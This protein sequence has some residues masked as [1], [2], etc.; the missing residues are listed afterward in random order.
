MNMHRSITL[1]TVE[2]QEG[3]AKP[4]TQ[5][6]AELLDLFLRRWKLVAAVSAVV[7][8]LVYGYLLTLTPLY[9]ATTVL[10]FEP[11]TENLVGQNIISGP[12]LDQAAIDSQL[13]AIGSNALLQRVVTDQNLLA[14]PEFGGKPSA[15]MLQRVT[16]ILTSPFSRAAPESEPTG[17]T[18]MAGAVDASSARMAL[19]VSRLRNAIEVQ[20]QPRAWA[21]NISVT[22]VNRAKAATLAD[23]VADAFIDDKLEARYERARRAANWLASRIEVLGADVKKAEQAVAEYRARYNIAE[24]R[25]ATLSD[26][27][28]TD[29]NGRLVNLRAETAEKRVKFEQAKALQASGNLD[30]IPDVVNSPVVAGLRAQA[31][32]VTR[33]EADLLARYGRSHPQVINV[34]AEK[35]DIERQIQAEAQRAIT[36][37]KND[38]DLAASR[39]DALD[40]SLGRLHAGNDSTVI[41]GLRELERTASANKVLY[42]SFLSRAKVA[43]EEAALESRDV[44]VLTNALVPGSPSYPRTNR[45]LAIALL[46]GLAL[47]AG[48]AFALEMLNRG[49]ISPRQVEAALNLPV[50]ASLPMVAKRDL[51]AGM[52]EFNIGE[53]LLAKPLSH[54]SEAIRS[55][56]TSVQMSDVDDPP[57]VIQV[58]SSI[59][60]EGKTT[61]CIALATSAAMIGHKVLLIDGDLR[62]PSTSRAFGLSRAQGLVDC[63]MAH[64]DL[65]PV[66]VDPR[67]GVHVLPAGSRTQHPPDLLNSAR[68]RT[69]MAEYRRQY[70]YIIMDSPPL[71]P[72]IDGSV[73]SLLADKVVF[74]VSWNKAPRELVAEAIQSIRGPRKTA[75]V[76][77][78]MVDEAAMPRYGRYAY[79]G[80]ST[81]G[82]YYSG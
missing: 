77:F 55:V 58:T 28:I 2:D 1:P 46:A 22:S 3:P 47:G 18:D 15:S 81:Y 72:V 60:S 74:A 73:I 29:L 23:A 54:F 33:R 69:L 27:Q 38:L 53:Y 31:S 21:A 50:L 17:E 70:D 61:T 68:M 35:R 62:N 12:S 57:K 7:V 19:A 49:F 66:H 82:K 40:R 41:V 56:R 9:T 71:A 14:D 52:E 43:G 11:R 10:L 64:D 20:R 5:T 25:A 48:G 30:A 67:S 34:Q 36:S 80:K 45:I 75:G 37:L 79:Y 65:H 26:Q 13:L 78:T 32:E 16:S 6:I 4:A 76:V 51:P 8:A 59:P 63:L 44:R 39:E 42:E 24:Q